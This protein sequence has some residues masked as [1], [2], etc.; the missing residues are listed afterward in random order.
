MEKAKDAASGISLC[1]YHGGRKIRQLL[2]KH[3]KIIVPTILQK[4]IVDWYHTLLCR[5][6]E[7]RME[8]TISQH[9][10]WKN[11]RKTVHAVCTKCNICQRTKRT[12]KKYGHLP[13]KEAK[14]VPWDT[15]CVDLI[16]LYNINVK[17]RKNHL[18]CGLLQ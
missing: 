2:V 17:T 9:L 11:L 3:D 14:T 12:K 6:G 10:T 13:P 5:P 8:N 15:L 4:P 7:I 1:S 16:G 18:R